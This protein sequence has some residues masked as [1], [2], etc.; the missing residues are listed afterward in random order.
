MTIF[1]GISVLPSVQLAQPQPTVLGTI[2]Q[3]QPSAIQCGVISSEQLVLSSTPTLEMFTDSTGSMFVSSQPMYYGLETIVSNTVMS[4][5]QFVASTVPQVLASSYQTTTQVFQASKLME[6]MVDVQAV[7]AMPSVPTVQAVQGVPGMAGSYVVVNQP[8]P[9]TDTISTPQLNVSTNPDSNFTPV[10]C[11]LS[12]SIEPQSVES[13]RPIQTLETTVR[14]IQTLETSVRPI[15]TL[16]TSCRPIHTL[17]SSVRP[18]QTLETSSVRPI[19]NLETSS[20]VD[21]HQNQLN[22]LKPMQQAIQTIPRVAVRPNPTI[23]MN[24]LESNPWKINEPL[25]GSEQPIS[26]SVRPYFDSKHVSE[27]TS[28]IKSSI[29]SKIPPLHNHC[30]THRNI[31]NKFNHDVNSVHSTYSSSLTNTNSNNSTLNNSPVISN[32]SAQNK[33]TIPTINAPTSRPMNRVLPMQAVTPKLDSIKPNQKSDIALDE[34]TKPEIKSIETEIDLPPK[35]IS[36]VIRPEIKLTVNNLEMIVDAT[37][38][39]FKLL[40]EFEE[41]DKDILKENFKDN[42]K[43]SLRENF[44]ESA[45]EN[46][47]MNLKESVKEN[48][49]ENVDNVINFKDNL[50]E[51]SKE[52]VKENLKENAKEIETLK[53]HESLKETIKENA[54]ESIKEMKE[55]VRE[56]IKEMKEYVKENIKEMK[57]TI[58][59]ISKVNMKEMAKENIK[60]NV[61]INVKENVKN[62]KEQMKDN[63]K[64]KMKENI[65]ENFKNQ[66][67]DLE[68]N[69]PTSLK[70]VL[71]KQLQDG[72]YKITHNLTPTNQK[73]SQVNSVQ[74]MSTQNQQT[75][76]LQLL[77]IKTFT[78]KTNAL[79]EKTESTNNV[80]F[81]KMKSPPIAVKKP[82]LAS[83]TVNSMKNGKPPITTQKKKLTGPS[84]MYEIKSQDGFTHT[85]SSMTE[86]WETVFQAV[87]SARK[88]HNLPPLPHNPLTENLGLE[89]NATIYLVE[90]L[91]GVNRC[92]K[93]KPK[94]HN[95]T[96]PKPGEAESDLLMECANGAARAEP[97]K[98]RKVHDV[99]SWLASRHRQQPKLI[100]IT[101]NESRYLQH[102]FHIIITNK[103]KIMRP[104]NLVKLKFFLE[105]TVRLLI[106]LIPLF[107]LF[108]SLKKN[109]RKSY[110]TPFFQ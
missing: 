22:S 82:R 42:L 10:A 32:P 59:E 52:N 102:N 56:S 20:I 109:H 60:E 21:I 39:N 99:F 75:K 101:E 80:N 49:N 83:K 35:E 31:V 54:R 3:Q 9:L 81:M 57:G 24:P 45:M 105:I 23:Q 92:T 108:S 13:V 104:A 46:V 65:K 67:S 70:I 103:F 41:N 27:N 38:E 1:S 77:P 66:K 48:L 51:S 43:E 107:F 36:P 33:I 63:L 28:M 87:Q 29:S 40:E 30:I 72:S 78:L 68:S 73:K 19:Q 71:Q 15:H 17:E 18:I 58:K 55:N 4:S 106:Y 97:F 89:N 16:E 14:P 88:A 7:S 61:K 90:Q 6:P 44:K 50:K 8:P 100:A 37:A 84:L 64:E 110:H 62:L 53:L 74:T 95:L 94:F 47:R 11:T 25:L 5:S 98:E 34:P 93:Y 86:V 69:P 96:P 2:I 79:S 26:N 76:S 91:P 85:A 12:S